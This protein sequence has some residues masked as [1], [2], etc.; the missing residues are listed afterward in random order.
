MEGN[1]QRYSKYLG[2]TTNYYKDE[3]ATDEDALKTVL[4]PEDDAAHVNW[5]GEWRMPTR[6][7]QDE[8]RNNCYWQWVTSYKGKSVSGYIAY[9]VKDSADKGKDSS[10]Y[11]PNVAYSVSDS[12]IFFPAAGYRRGSNLDYADS[13]GYY[14]SSSLYV[15]GSSYAY[16][17][18]IYLNH[19]NW[20][21]LSRCY[22]FSVRPVCQ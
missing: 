16:G 15:S 7:E 19:V 18:S 9:K 12:H 8:I 1:S 21:Y 3:N 10:N 5:G 4:D 6:A 17:L 2:S 22:G 20:S 11:T 13:D 14:W